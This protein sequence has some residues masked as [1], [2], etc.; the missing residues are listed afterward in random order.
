MPTVSD[1]LYVQRI[2]QSRG[3]RHKLKVVRDRMA[4]A[5]VQLAASEDANVTITLSEGTRPKGRSY[6]RISI[7]A[8]DEFG[9]SKTKRLR[10]LG[11][12]V[13]R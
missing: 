11:R 13:G 7:P 6:A 1:Y 4:A 10:L 12:V 5:A 3:V 9:D 2:L 8:T